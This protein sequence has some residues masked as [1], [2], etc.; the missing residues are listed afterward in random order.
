VFYAFPKSLHP[1]WV[2]DYANKVFLDKYDTMAVYAEKCTLGY[3][4]LFLKKGAK[5]CLENDG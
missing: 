3:V 1:P 4:I 2:N 5:S